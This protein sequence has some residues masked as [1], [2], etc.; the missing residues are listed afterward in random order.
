TIFMLHLPALTIPAL[1]SSL[2]LL[3][4]F[5]KLRKRNSNLPGDVI[6]SEAIGPV[7]KIFEPDANDPFPIDQTTI[8]CPKDTCFRLSCFKYG[9]P[10]FLNI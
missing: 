2:S 10:I 1:R 5:V 6:D 4:Y 7:P 8:H 3:H 9:L